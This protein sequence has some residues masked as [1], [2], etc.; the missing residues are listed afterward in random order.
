MKYLVPHL[1]VCVYCGITGESV[2][3]S[4]KT[5]ADVDFL[6]QCYTG[7]CDLHST[8]LIDG[9]FPILPLARHVKLSM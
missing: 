7:H 2:F 8:V 1:N 6:D 9:V 5:M 3:P 4:V